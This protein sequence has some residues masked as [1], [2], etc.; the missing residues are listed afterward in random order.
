M[1]EDLTQKCAVTDFNKCFG[2]SVGVTDIGSV[3][4]S[5]HQI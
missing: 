2:I 4:L 1:I 3:I 5:N